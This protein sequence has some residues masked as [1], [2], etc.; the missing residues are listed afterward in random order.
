MLGMRYFSK[1]SS[2]SK[3]F[4][5]EN[6]LNGTDHVDRSPR[7]EEVHL[8]GLGWYVVPG[9]RNTVGLRDDRDRKS[10][11]ARLANVRTSAR[12]VHSG[13]LMGLEQP[14][15]HAAG[16]WSG[17]SAEHSSDL[18]EEERS[19]AVVL[20][21]VLQA[22]IRAKK[23]HL[24]RTRCVFIWSFWWDGCIGYSLRRQTFRQGRRLR[25]TSSSGG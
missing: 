18:G 4:V 21:H 2:K 3:M 17:S 15:G 23:G 24:T 20:V 7:H 13:Y 22:L 16:P 5:D 1:E 14:G 25:W 8:S 11:F 10:F 12:G 9:V 6:D 19:S